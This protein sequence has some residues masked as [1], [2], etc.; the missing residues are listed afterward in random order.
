MERQF[1]AAEPQ[2]SPCGI[3]RLAAPVT[4][5]EASGGEEGEEERGWRDWWEAAA[6]ITI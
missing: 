4:H 6:G 3:F 1:F 2:Q 5:A